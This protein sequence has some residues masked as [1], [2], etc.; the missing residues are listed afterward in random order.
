MKSKR[1]TRMVEF[2]IKV[3]PTARTAYLPKE[4]FNVLGASATAV[5]SREVV[6]LFPQNTQLED[7]LKSLQIVAEDLE[8]QQLKKKTV[9]DSS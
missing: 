8:Y 9:A 6:I 3:N 5:T 1:W 2:R 4:V 7:V